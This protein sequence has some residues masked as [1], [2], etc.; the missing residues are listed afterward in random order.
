[1]KRRNL[2]ALA[3][4][5][6]LAACGGVK[7]YADQGPGN[8]QLKLSSVDGGFMTSRAVYLD[9]WTG[10]KG[11]DMEYLGTR[12]FAKDGD[13][14]GLPTGQPLHLAIAFEEAGWLGGDTGTDTIELPMKAIRPGQMY[15]LT[16]AY[17]DIGFDW[18][19][20]RVR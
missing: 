16:V 15:R 5:F 19:L 10:P 2:L 11:P 18:D 3:A 1:M 8:M 20:D 6:A 4:A 14:V 7:P 13:V 9:V 17:D 12:K